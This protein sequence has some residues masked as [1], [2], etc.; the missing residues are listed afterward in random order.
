MAAWGAGVSSARAGAA[1]R[2]KRIA[3]ARAFITPSVLWE[4]SRG[5]GKKKGPREGGPDS[6]T[7]ADVL[8]PFRCG[9]VDE[10]QGLRPR[11]GGL[12]AIGCL[13]PYF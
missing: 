3:L 7:A 10:P 6:D 1:R 12:D 9:P 5:Q 8:Y 13:E 4:G 2:R 11:R